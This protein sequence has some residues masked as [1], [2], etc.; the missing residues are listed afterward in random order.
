MQYSDFGEIRKRCC[1]SLPADAHTI[2]EHLPVGVALFEVHSWRLL[3][4]NAAYES[5]LDPVWQ[6]GQAIGHQ[7]SE[8]F[9]QAEA[10][11]VV[12]L[13]RQVAQK[14]TPAQLEL[15]VFPSAL[16]PH[17]TYWTWALSPL[18]DPIGE[19]IQIL[20][21]VSN[22]TSQMLTWQQTESERHDVLAAVRDAMQQAQGA[23]HQA[24]AALA[25][26]H[27]ALQ[28][29]LLAIYTPSATNHACMLLTAHPSSQVGLP[30]CLLHQDASGYPS[31]LLQAGFQ[32]VPSLASL[33]HS[34]DGDQ[35]KEDAFWL[36]LPG[37]RT[38]LCVPLWFQE[39]WE[40]ILV[41]A[42]GDSLP[43]SYAT[44]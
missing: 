33:P 6:K 31:F 42:L 34:L 19:V 3:A 5:L 43:T 15:S 35:N 20:L 12:T 29:R 11:D 44:R 17:N 32:R 18:L 22:M 13:F 28:T 9:P 4:A 41:A 2:L 14:R 39:R 1:S 25:T 40:G 7:L 26:L 23:E 21:T 30:S 16:P 36:K 10:S 38:L 8:F 37:A 24:Q 27:T